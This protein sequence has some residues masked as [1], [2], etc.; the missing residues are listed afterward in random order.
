MPFTHISIDNFRTFG[1]NKQRAKFDIAP[2][3]ILTG[4][5]SSGKSSLIKALMLLNENSMMEK[6]PF[7][8]DLRGKQHLLSN[9]GNI[10]SK[11]K[12]NRNAITFEIDYSYIYNKK[13]IKNRQTHFYKIKLEYIPTKKGINENIYLNRL[14]IFARD[15]SLIFAMRN[16]VRNKKNRDIYFNFLYFLNLFLADDNFK[17][18]DFDKLQHNFKQDKNECMFH[19]KFNI[20]KRLASNKYFDL[21]PLK[22]SVKYEYDLN[23]LMKSILPKN[24][25]LD[26]NDRYFNEAFNESRQNL[27]CQLPFLDN[28]N[29]IMYAGN[30]I[31]ND[32]LA[33]YGDAAT[34]E[35]QIQSDI[36][37][38]SF[39]KR[40]NKAI[41]K[42]IFITTDLKDFLGAT[43]G[44]TK[45]IVQ[46]FIT[47]MEHEVYIPVL[48][49]AVS[50]V[51][52]DNT[53]IGDAIFQLSKIMSENKQI[54]STIKKW[55][56][57]FGL[58]EKFEINRI[59]GYGSEILFFDE[60]NIKTSLK[61]M[62]FG[63]S[64]LL[65][66]I[67]NIFAKQIYSSASD[68]KNRIQDSPDYT[69]LIEEPESHLHPEFQS[70]LA[71]MFLDAVRT[72]NNTFIIE[73][74]SEYLI[75]KFQYLIAAK[76][77]DTNELDVYYLGKDP[78]NK[79]YIKKIE[80]D[81]NGMI[82]KDFGEGFFDE[83]A[84]LITHLW[85]LPRGNKND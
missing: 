36:D 40:L 54:T 80:L 3:T 84:N 79:D 10:Q 12:Q 59:A 5:N 48:R 52:K 42:K 15:K 26:R 33:K 21:F 76:Q 50:H 4:T 46:K 83:A 41:F 22:D 13:Q 55:F 72:S 2:V 78:T 82:I 7:V 32:L 66:I 61:D 60:N 62:G 1:A 37:L 9:F 75:R 19:I 8:L 20:P 73:T 64:Q 44:Y 43:I 18:F 67:I 49:G 58:S 28:R 23:N 51:F 30:Y 17:H 6:F 77:M 74:H 11:F 29:N 14:E 45:S 35:K 56:K 81:S 85:D 63:Y 71:D 47:E 69:F 25:V 31:F 65:P 39:S 34:I 70:K 38:F 24:F 27:Y 53:L 57:E 16:L 68:K